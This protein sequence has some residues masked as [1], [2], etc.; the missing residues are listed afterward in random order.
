MIFRLPALWLVRRQELR[1]RQ[2]DP[3]GEK[4]RKP[5]RTDVKIDQIS[6]DIFSLISFM[7]G[8]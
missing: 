5:R 1:V 3:I 8:Y 2:V 7:L 4:S 6:Q